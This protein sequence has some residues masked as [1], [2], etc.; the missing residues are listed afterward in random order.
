MSQKRRNGRRSAGPP[1][2]RAELI[3]LIE[4]RARALGAPEPDQEVVEIALR[5]LQADMEA[6]SGYSYRAEPPLDCPLLV[7]GGR[8]DREVEAAALL[9]WREQTRSEFHLELVP[10]DHF[11]VETALP[12]V[13]GL[14][15]SRLRQG[16]SVNR[17]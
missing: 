14:I 8:E 15:G 4:G 3:R 11:F 12:L 16:Q 7:L 10:G 2:A 9:G 17:P 13:L 6:S 5:P 1:P